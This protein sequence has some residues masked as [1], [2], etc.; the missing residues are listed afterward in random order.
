MGESC[1]ISGRE[2]RWF[3]ISELL[4]LED[5]KE[6]RVFSSTREA[7]RG[8]GNGR[9]SCYGLIIMTYC[10]KEEAVVFNSKRKANRGD[11]NGRLS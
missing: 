11:R 6:L 9:S 3:D 4:L 5:G 1:L 8:E 7:N 10:R 2:L